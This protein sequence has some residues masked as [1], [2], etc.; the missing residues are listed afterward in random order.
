MTPCKTI[1][2]WNLSPPASCLFGT[3]LLWPG[4]PLLLPV[5]VFCFA[6]YAAVE[7]I[8]MKITNLIDYLLDKILGHGISLLILGFWAA[9]ACSILTWAGI[10]ALAI[11]YSWWILAGGVALAIAIQTILSHD[12]SVVKLFRNMPI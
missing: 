11:T 12:E 4:I 5:V 10:V 8:N 2:F 7:K 1:Q 6:I 9:I 3:F